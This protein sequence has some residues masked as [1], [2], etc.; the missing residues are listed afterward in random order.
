M[1]KPPCRTE[2]GPPASCDQGAWRL[3]RGCIPVLHKFNGIETPLRGAQTQRLSKL[4]ALCL[5][6]DGLH[7]E[8]PA[9]LKFASSSRTHIYHV[10]SAV[11]LRAATRVMML[12]VLTSDLLPLEAVLTW[13]IPKNIADPASWLIRHHE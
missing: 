8:S 10:G 3:R 11:K 2:L 4:A 5:A 12:Q 1:G 13:N 9:L 6:S 7:L